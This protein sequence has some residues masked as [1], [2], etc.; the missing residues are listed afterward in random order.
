MQTEREIEIQRASENEKVREGEGVR[1]WVLRS[2]RWIKK[3]AIFIKNYKCWSYT[4]LSAKRRKF[5]NY[6]KFWLD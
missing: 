6:Q 2:G 4:I 1:M 5:G 3:F